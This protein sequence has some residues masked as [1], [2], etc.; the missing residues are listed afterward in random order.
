MSSGL[1]GDVID[2]HMGMM[3]AMRNSM[4]CLEGMLE[5]GHECFSRYMRH[6]T[7]S[8]GL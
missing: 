2:A 5:T 1:K 3:A 7:Y 6:G 8:L 4:M